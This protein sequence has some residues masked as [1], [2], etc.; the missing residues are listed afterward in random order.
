MRSLLRYL[1]LIGYMTSLPSMLWA[2]DVNT[3]RL[4]NTSEHTRVVFEVSHR[5]TYNI[6][7]MHHPERVVIDM[8]H[9]HLAKHA[10]HV[11]LPDPMVKSIRHGV[12]QGMLRMVLDLHHGN[13]DMRSFFLKK[14]HGA[15][16][17]LVVDL[18]PKRDESRSSHV[19]T[20]KVK[21]RE[22]VVA[23]DAGHGGEDPGAIGPKGLQEKEVTLAIARKLVHLLN[24]QPG[25]RG[26]LTR[27]ND[28][29][30]PLKKRVKLVRSAHADLMISIHADAVRE[31]SVLGSSV[32]T[33]SERG[34]TADKVAIALAAKENAADEMGGIPTSHDELEDVMVRNILGDMA[35][36][37]SLNSSQILAESVLSYLKGVGK[38]KYH[39]PKRARFVVLSALEIPSVLVEV[40][41][42][43]N[44]RQERKLRGAR[45]RDALAKALYQASQSFFQRM[46]MLGKKVAERSS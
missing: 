23:V 33:L 12:H 13:T 22:L 31:R 11:K 20:S 3:V 43:S 4:S 29:V 38:L 37:D 6:F 35:K 46:G 5:I 16:R 27:K 2:A 41:F 21:Q 42:I 17:R 26:V 25:V 28:Y 1:L 32:Y 39:V 44:P 40:D 34:A 18:I 14:M 7:R 15:P 8:K 36:R 30:V 19:R 45:Y 10:M 9:T 24:K